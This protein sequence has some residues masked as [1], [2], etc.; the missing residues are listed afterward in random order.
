MGAIVAPSKPPEVKP[1][2]PPS[3]LSL[4]WIHGLSLESSYDN[5]R[6]DGTKL[7]QDP[8]NALAN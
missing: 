7:T 3:H 2:L 1:G 5:V 6:C 8:M 4:D